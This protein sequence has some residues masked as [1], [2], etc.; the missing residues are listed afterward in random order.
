MKP[1]FQAM[2]GGG[3]Q[4][5][6]L[7]SHLSRLLQEEK[8][9]DVLEELETAGIR[10][11][12]EGDS[13]R[14][15]APEG[16]LSEGL[17]SR[18][19]QS[20]RQM[21]V[22]LRLAALAVNDTGS[23]RLHRAVVCQDYHEVER[24]VTN[25]ARVNYRNRYGQS[26]FWLAVATGDER[27][28]EILALAGGDPNVADLDGRTC[29]HKAV[30]EGYERIARFL[31]LNGAEVNR[32][33]FF[34]HTPLC[35]AI[36]QENGGLAQLLNE[37]GAT[38][39]D[40]ENFTQKERDFLQLVLRL[41]NNFSPELREHSLRVADVARFLALHLGADEVEAKTV[42]LG[43]M[44]HDVGKVS[45]PDNIFD[46]ADEEVTEEDGELLESHPEDGYNALSGEEYQ[47][48]WDFRPIIL[49]HHE[50]WDGEGYPHG[51]KGED[52]PLGPQLV[53]LADYYD[54]LVTHREH[55]PAVPPEEAIEHLQELA[56]AHFA[57]GLPA[58]LS[59][60]AEDILVY[61]PG[62]E[63]V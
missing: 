55:D 22:V 33:D 26:P 9:L 35:L 52:L 39:S 5:A 7:E 40:E 36:A 46:Q 19:R 47:V 41:L 30:T 14:H 51:L 28:V 38:I 61:S 16:V 1:S 63:R 44:L 31:L 45:L 49:H 18:L 8:F 34:A 62:S 12:I 50:R 17:L 23:T 29:L 4:A 15:Q 13:F 57:P 59:E 20:N 56:G 53:G 58:I 21:L 6:K 37:H 48:R 11:T 60:V 24:L 3:G 2:F 10:L 25:G 42:R 54:H 43:G 32:G 27:L